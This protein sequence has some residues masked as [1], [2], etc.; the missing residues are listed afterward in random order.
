MET[1]ASALTHEHFFNT[2]ETLKDQLLELAVTG[3]FFIFFFF[4]RNKK[5][6]Q[7]VF[8]FLKKEIEGRKGR[9]QTQP[10]L[11]LMNRSTETHLSDKYDF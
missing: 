1:I 3:N 11:F 7:L 5:G 4:K 2:R 6:Q 10:C 8:S 9:K